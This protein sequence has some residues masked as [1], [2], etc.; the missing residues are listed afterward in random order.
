SLAARGGTYR[1]LGLQL[2]IAPA[3]GGVRGWLR[4]KPYVE[5]PQVVVDLSGWG[6]G[7][8]IPLGSA[9]LSTGLW[10]GA[11]LLLVFEPGAV[12]RK[13]LEARRLAF[14]LAVPDKILGAR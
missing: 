8:P 9:R 3:R 1:S 6:L 13:G 7:G 2:E 4:L 10:Q 12:D 11:D 14:E 5:I